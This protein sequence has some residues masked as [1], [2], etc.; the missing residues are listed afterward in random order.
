ML[1]VLQERSPPVY[2]KSFLS[3][4]S[5]VILSFNTMYADR[6]TAQK[7]SFG[8]YL[9]TVIQYGGYTESDG[10]MKDE[11]SNT[12]DWEGNCRRLF[13]ISFQNLLRGPRRNDVKTENY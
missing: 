9:M 4:Y 13:E 1:Y 12:K 6:R 7:F 11:C 10:R 8:G 2:F 5:P 3:H